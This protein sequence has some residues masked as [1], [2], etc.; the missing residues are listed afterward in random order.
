MRIPHSALVLPQIYTFVGVGPALQLPFSSR[1]DA[2][3]SEIFADSKMM[4]NR[5]SR[6]RRI[7]VFGERRPSG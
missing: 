6:T 7:L 3:A 1:S 4:K 5:S 2:K